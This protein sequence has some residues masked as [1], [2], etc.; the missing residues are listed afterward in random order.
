MSQLVTER[1]YREPNLLQYYKV[2][3]AAMKA[4]AAQGTEQS[5][6]VQS[7]IFG[8]QNSQKAYQGRYEALHDKSVVAKKQKEED[9][10]HQLVKANP[11]LE[12]ECGGAWATIDGAEVKYRPMIKQQIF[13]RT[14]STLSS[15]A[16]TIVQYVME[17]KKA[18]GEITTLILDDYS[19]V[20]VVSGPAAKP[21]E[22]TQTV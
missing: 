5:R 16:I 8:L 10:F 13:R 11:A 14:D 7:I 19:C 21:D 15:L 17:I 22:A 6:Q 2:R 18:D 3:I 1:D 20:E 4:Y 12:A 9:D